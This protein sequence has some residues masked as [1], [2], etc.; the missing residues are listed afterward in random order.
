MENNFHALHSLAHAIPV[1][2]VAGNNFHITS[3]RRMI[4]PAPRTQGIIVDQGPRCCSKL[5]QPFGQMTTDKS[6]GTGD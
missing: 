3:N 6:A 4:E 5:N 1:A 2:N